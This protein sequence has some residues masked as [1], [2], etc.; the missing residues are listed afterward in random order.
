MNT[1]KSTVV[2]KA[3]SVVAVLLLV[4]TASAQIGPPSHPPLVISAFRLRG[5]GAADAWNEFIE[6][7]NKS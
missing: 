7:Y 6:I 1:P 4:A 3:L 5:P 2:V